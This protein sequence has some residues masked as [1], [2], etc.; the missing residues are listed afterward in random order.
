M[1]RKLVIFATIEVQPGT[2][3]AAVKEAGV[4]S[5]SVTG[6]PFRFADA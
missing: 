2:R 5:I 4:K 3:E 6:V 1:N